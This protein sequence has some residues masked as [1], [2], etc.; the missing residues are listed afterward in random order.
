MKQVLQPRAKDIDEPKNKH[1]TESQGGRAGQREALKRK[2]FKKLPRQQFLTKLNMVSPYSPAIT[3]LG[4]NPSEL[5]TYVNI[6]PAHR[7]L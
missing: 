2:G 4:I 3:V 5:E 1:A 7:S 6:K